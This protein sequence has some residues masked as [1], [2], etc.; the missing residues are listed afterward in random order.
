MGVTVGGLALADCT[1][2]CL[3]PI[4]PA[5]AGPAAHANSKLLALT[6]VIPLSPARIATTH[7]HHRFLGCSCATP[8]P[9]RPPT[10]HLY[11]QP[12]HTD[13]PL[14]GS[15][16]ALLPAIEQCSAVVVARRGARTRGRQVPP[17]SPGKDELT[18]Q[19]APLARSPQGSRPPGGRQQQQQELR[20]PINIVPVAVQPGGGASPQQAPIAR[21]MH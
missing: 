1:C 10:T 15:Q 18:R 11:P 21:A 17:S 5:S 4:T 7:H 14:V 19:A 12:E 2:A 8:P 16:R 6:Y 20:S 13:V 9:D 3:L